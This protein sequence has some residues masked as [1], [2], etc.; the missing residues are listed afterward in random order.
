MENTTLGGQGVRKVW[1]WGFG[2]LCSLQELGSFPSSWA[3]RV[4]WVG[5]AGE[6]RV[7]L[8]AVPK[9]T[10]ELYE[11]ESSVE[12]NYHPL[13]VEL[14]TWAGDDLFLALASFVSLWSSLVR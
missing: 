14:S 6:G 8:A 11:C 2:T 3:G 10:G 1:P 13:C 12:T 7:G 9:F 4:V 5:W